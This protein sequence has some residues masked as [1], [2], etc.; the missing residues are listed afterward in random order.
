MTI[1]IDRTTWKRRGNTVN[2]PVPSVCFGDTGIPPRVGYFTAGYRRMR[3]A[4][5]PF[6]EK[7]VFDGE[8]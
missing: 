6:R 4:D 8:V 5:E 7:S 2:L 3:I 1:A